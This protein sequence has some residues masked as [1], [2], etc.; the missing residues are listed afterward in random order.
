MRVVD[1]KGSLKLPKINVDRRD[2]LVAVLAAAAV[3]SIAFCGW[4][5]FV[6]YT[7]TSRVAAF[8]RHVAASEADL[9]LLSGNIS[10]HMRSRPGHPSIAECDAW[11]RELGALADYGRGLTSYHRQ[12]I[13]ADVV[14]E[15]YTGSQSAYTRALDNLN[16]AF[17]LWSSAAGAYHTGA[18][19]AAN[20][21]LAGADRAWKDYITAISDYD[22]ELRRA[23]EGEEG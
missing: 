20:N 8:S 16:R 3:I 11:M 19:T 5:L 17:S 12:V 7:E 9:F 6:D 18:Y 13:A 2:A 4:T 21:N 23:E 22:R 15:A 14:P 1:L 10:S